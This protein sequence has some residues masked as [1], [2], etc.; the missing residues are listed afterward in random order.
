[1][2]GGWTKASVPKRAS[3]LCTGSLLVF[4]PVPFEVPQGR[5]SPRHCQGN[6]HIQEWFVIAAQPRHNGRS[7][8]LPK[9]GNGEEAHS[10]ANGEGGQEFLLWIFHNPSCH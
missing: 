3:G 8:H 2:W 4:R 1:M 10:P 9:E 7:I 6:Q 5:D